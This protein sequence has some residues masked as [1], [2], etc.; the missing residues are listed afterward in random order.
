MIDLTLADVPNE[1]IAAC[2]AIVATSVIVGGVWGS[3][4]WWTS[5]KKRI[6]DAGIAAQK[7]DQEEK[8]ARDRLSRLEAKADLVDGLD[9]KLRDQDDR[10]K[11]TIVAAVATEVGKIGKTIDSVKLWERSD[12]NHADIE[13]LRHKTNDQLQGISNKLELILNQ[14]RDSAAW[15]E[16]HQNTDDGQFAEIR[17]A[18]K[19]AC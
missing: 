1:I 10:M 6:F 3:R 17:E 8:A 5:W 11:E 7:Q 19:R 14:Q 15:Q 2:E 4:K 9:E 12:Q 18:L 13:N 16:N